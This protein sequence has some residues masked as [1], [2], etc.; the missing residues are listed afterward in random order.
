MRKKIKET[1]EM[2][3]NCLPWLVC[4][5]LNLIVGDISRWTYGLTTAALVIIIWYCCPM[6]LKE[7]WDEKN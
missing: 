3:W 7:E 2:H 5:L 4:G 1:F 6:T